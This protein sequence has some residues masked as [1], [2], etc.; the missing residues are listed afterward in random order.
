[1]TVLFIGPL[2]EPVTGQSL[3][4]Q[5]FLEALRQSRPVEVINLSRRGFSHGID[6]P[7]RIAE[8]LSFIWRAR[9]LSRRCDTLYFTT[10]E[11]VAGNLKD[12]LIL[13]ACFNLLNRTV[14]HL[15]GGAGLK[16]LLHPE[17]RFLR[18]LNAFFLRRIGAM[19]V[20]GH[21]QV[22]MFDGLVPAERLHV[23]PNF[24]EDA[25]FVEPAAVEAKFAHTEPLRLLFLS[26]LLPGKG[27]V[28]LVAAF[29]LLDLAQRERVR[30]DFAGGFPDD[31]QR[32]DFLRSIAGM[33]QLAYHGMVRG[34]RKIRLFRQAHLFCLPTYYPFEGQPISILEAYASGC[35]VL[36][37][38]HSGI[39][40]VFAPGQN[41]LAVDKEMP[42]SI[43]RA[44]VQALADPTALRVMALRNLAEAQENYR[45]DRYNSRLLHVINTVGGR[46]GP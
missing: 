41:G 5:V 31:E 4:C 44:L 21:R 14:L 34:E 13:V 25:M 6:S 9:R 15:H 19:V 24:A 16:L 35:A 28:E 40:D 10:A 1:M 37:T 33:P 2:P 29:K 7:G 46:S 23:V 11:S 30:M 12:L 36:T 8:V 18:G 26:N 20:L 39:F 3:A 27:H 32:E 17:R 43:Q 42:D 45:A 22:S 38:D